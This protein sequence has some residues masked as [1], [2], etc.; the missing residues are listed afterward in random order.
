MK[1][2]RVLYFSSFANRFSV[3]KIIAERP[4][5]ENQS[6]TSFK[7]YFDF[8]FPHANDSYRLQTIMGLPV[9]P[10][11]IEN[12]GILKIYCSQRDNLGC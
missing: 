2:D 7:D 8:L 9:H 6:L 5:M 10:L 11:V 1:P 4:R 3:L 12:S